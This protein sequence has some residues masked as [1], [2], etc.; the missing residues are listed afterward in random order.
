[1]EIVVFH[2]RI[3]RIVATVSG[4]SHER[5]EA[6]VEP[7]DGAYSPGCTRRATWGIDLS[8]HTTGHAVDQLRR[9]QVDYQALQFI[10]WPG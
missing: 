2:W 3:Q 5:T 8:G 7:V 10:A 4:T 9:G 1:M 6:V